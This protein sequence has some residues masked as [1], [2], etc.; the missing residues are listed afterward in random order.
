M[1]LYLSSFDL[2]N[3]SEQLVNLVGKGKKV[4][5]IFNALDH[6]EEARNKW[7]GNQTKALEDLGFIVEELD[8]RK[9]F[10][11]EKKLQSFLNKKDLVWVNGGNTFILRRA[12]KYSGFD[13]LIKDLIKNDNIV[14]G[15]FSAGVVILSKD[16]H[17]LDI[18]DNPNEIPVGYDKRIIWKGLDIIDFSIAVHYKS[19]H[20]ESHLT[21]RE[22]EYYK[23]NNIPYKTL[24][25]GEVIIIN[26]KKIA[27]LS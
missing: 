15:G 5:I 21:D 10:K 18:T 26:N 1:K 6:R 19:N 20:H 2:G 12:M 14:Y 7:L 11:K 16:L 23:K 9:Y 8:L 22:V 3:Q 24:S 17:G 13:N 4:V 25:D 27:K